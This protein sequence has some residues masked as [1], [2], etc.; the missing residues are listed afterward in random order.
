MVM[1]ITFLGAMID[2]RVFLL[3]MRIPVIRCSERIPNMPAVSGVC[4]ISVGNPYTLSS[5]LNM[6]MNNNNNIDHIILLRHATAK[7]RAH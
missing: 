3:E 4:P 6:F 1:I 5:N 2:I 7:S